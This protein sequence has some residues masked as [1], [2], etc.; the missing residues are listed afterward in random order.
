[1]IYYCHIKNSAFDRMTDVQTQPESQ[2]TV[3]SF[4]FGLL[5]GG[6]LVWAFMGDGNHVDHPETSNHEDQATSTDKNPSETPDNNDTANEV[7]ETPTLTTGETGVVK[8]GTIKAGNSVSLGDV[9]YPIDEGWIGVREYTDGRLG[10]INGVVRFSKA[11]NLVPTEIPLVTPVRA[12]REYA[13]V[14][15]TEGGDRSFNSASDRQ[16]DTIFTTFKAE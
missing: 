7:T 14:M 1:M 16:L 5:I 8:L 10:Y 2:K 6:L 12:G 15:F 4:I 11:G 3:V 9:T 13:I